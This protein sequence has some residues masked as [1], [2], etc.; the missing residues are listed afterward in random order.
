M[1]SDTNLIK[2]NKFSHLFEMNQSKKPEDSLL[3]KISIGLNCKIPQ[4]FNPKLI[5]INVKDSSKKNLLILQKKRPFTNKRLKLIFK[6]DIPIIT[7]KQTKFKNLKFVRTPIKYVSKG[8]LNFLI[9]SLSFQNLVKSNNIFKDDIKD[10]FLPKIL[11]INQSFTKRKINSRNKKD[12]IRLSLSKSEYEK[13]LKITSGMLNS[14]R[15]YEK[16]DNKFSVN[17]LM[18]N[19]PKIN[20]LT[21]EEEENK[22][23]FNRNKRYTSRNLIN[24]K[25]KSNNFFIKRYTKTAMMNNLFKKYPSVN[26]S[27]SKSN[28]SENMNPNFLTNINISQ[29][30]N[31]Y[32]TKIKNDDIS[33]IS[34]RYN[35]ILLNI[36]KNNNQIININR[37]IYI[38][39]LLSK[40]NDKLNREKIFFAKNKKTIYEL[41]K[42]SS[43]RRLKKFED[44]IN[45][46]YRE[47][48]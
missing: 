26:S 43:Y 22:S 33:H 7:N 9:K 21:D 17:S 3:N 24:N 20:S 28:A 27:L 16:R 12:V 29:N 14:K 11:K 40:V 8:N 18:I 37:K 4:F 6:N 1:E 32:L 13:N 30:K 41:E 35:N 42:E 10:N 2:S 39:C 5:K 46:L 45:R 23:F 31:N 48:N 15:L 34:E 25:K 19:S 38:N 36:K 44:F 47:K